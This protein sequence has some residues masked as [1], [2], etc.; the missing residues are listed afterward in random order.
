MVRIAHLADVHLG[1]AFAW[2]GAEDKARR[3]RRQQLDGL[4]FCL[5]TAREKDCAAVLIAGDLFEDVY[6]RQGQVRRR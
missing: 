5:Q 1:S 3:F 4:N 2:T 6:K